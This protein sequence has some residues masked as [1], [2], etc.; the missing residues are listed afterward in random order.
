[1]S[2]NCNAEVTEVRLTCAETA[3]EIRKM[4]K[5]EFPGQKFSVRSKSYAGGASVSINWVDGPGEAAVK[6]HADR[7]AGATFDGMTDMKSYRDS[8]LIANEDGSYEDVRYGADFVSCQR[9]IS[10]ETR[11]RYRA[12]IVAL[13][14]HDFDDLGRIPVHVDRD[15]SIMPL[16]GGDEWASTVIYRMS[17]ARAAPSCER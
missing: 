10:D 9:E 1:M 16:G 14:G 11:G 8:T 6:A 7:F 5:A 4:L 3:K 12:E 17:V 13:L 2:S 15:G